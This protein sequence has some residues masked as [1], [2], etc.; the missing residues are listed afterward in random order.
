MHECTLKMFY[1]INLEGVSFYSELFQR[2]HIV[3]ISLNSQVRRW[4]RT[5]CSVFL[6][7]FFSRFGQK[8]ELSSFVPLSGKQCSS[9]LHGGCCPCPQRTLTFIQPSRRLQTEGKV[10]K[11]PWM[12]MNWIKADHIG[13][14]NAE[15]PPSPAY[16]TPESFPSQYLASLRDDGGSA[17]LTQGRQSASEAAYIGLKAS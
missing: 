8:L 10:F 9:F 11:C 3:Q 5:C 17:V 2:S 1:I 6:L 13:P 16:L 14:L 7:F 4:I 15:A 12:V